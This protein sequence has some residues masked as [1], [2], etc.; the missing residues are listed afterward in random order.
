MCGINGI[1][2]SES[3]MNSHHRSR[4]VSL[5][6]N[7]IA[8]RGPDAEGIWSADMVTLGH[9]RLSIIDLS[10]EANQPMIDFSDQYVIVYNGEIY[11]YKE[12]R[13]ELSRVEHGSSRHPFLFKTNSDTEVILAAYATYGA[14]CLNYLNGMF[15]FAIWNQ[16]KKELFLARDRFGIKPI[17]FHFDAGNLVFSS[18]LRSILA[19]GV[20]SKRVSK[21]SL[22]DYLMYQT[23]HAPHTI[24]EDVKML[25]P[26]HFLTWKNGEIQLAE[27][28][29]PVK[30]A[31]K[32]NE[33]YDYKFAKEK[34]K[35]L[36][37]SSVERR[38][39]ADVPVGAFLS[40]GIDSS[41][42]VAAMAHHSL[43]PVNT[44]HVTFDNKS[45]SEAEFANLVS[46]KYRTKHFE[47][48]L[49]S[50]QILKDLPL[51]LNH[52]DHPSGD[53]INTYIVSQASKQAGVSVVLSGLGGDELFCGYNI[54]ARMYSFESNAWMNLVPRFIR[55]LVGELYDSLKGTVPSAKLK[56]L[57]SLSVMN[58]HY[59]YPISRQ[60]LSPAKVR[61]LL[62]GYSPELNPVYRIIRTTDRF[63]SGFRLSDYSVAEIKTYLLNTLLRDADQMSM[64]HALEIRLPF[65][66]Y[67]LAEFV[68]GMK[69]QFKQY[70]SPK[71]LL[72][73]S[74]GDLLPA[75][76]LNRP[77]M[78]FTFPWE[79]WMRNE[80]KD[81]CT[82]QLNT[83]KGREEI[84]SKEVL[85]LWSGFLK[86]KKNIS[87]SQLWH[88]V[89]LG[90][91]MKLNGIN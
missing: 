15:S 37:F 51:L 59:A 77:K 61:T 78:G 1:I 47:I 60:V 20:S 25:M 14:D 49:S 35:N 65:L 38:M 56:Q 19:S 70:K 22:Y 52:F 27:W 91:W 7:S 10:E 72:I 53:G 71:K 80:L 85:D 76:I 66:D 67:E 39:I 88:L 58:F 16:K 2:F 73:D 17:Y 3:A 11:N 82:D 43:S 42:V 74:M 34:V 68:L 54:F 29:N 33:P 23:V 75:E 63:S 46:K 64:R 12:L 79:T 8:H 9:R 90:N 55:V 69:D 81:F 84:N 41:A 21:N 57:L 48:A 6:N 18:E 44:F 40:G 24:I 13:F 26:G 31:E 83:F 30:N 45:F 32:I 4:L 86:G 50:N 36:F 62:K 89:V 28:W 87:W 5:M